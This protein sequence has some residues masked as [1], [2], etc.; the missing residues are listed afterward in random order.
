[1]NTKSARYSLALLVCAVPL[2]GACAGMMGNGDGNGSSN[3]LIG[4]TWRLAEIKASGD[5]PQITNDLR[6][7]H[8]ISFEKTGGVAMQLD[9][10]R[11]RAAWSAERHHTRS[12]DLSIG[13]VASTRALCPDPSFGDR[14]AQDLPKARKYRI[15]NEGRR[16]VIE[17]GDVTY[18]FDAS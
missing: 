11:G 14:M 3:P 7:R 9:C 17:A 12:G 5:A 10:N 16:L 18:A 8:T 6:E 2:V 15:E 1:M 4:P 13:P